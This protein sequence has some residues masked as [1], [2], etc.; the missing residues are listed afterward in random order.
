MSTNI[1]TNKIPRKAYA[2]D[3][4]RRRSKILDLV[5]GATEGLT[6]KEIL[7]KLVS[8]NDDPSLRTV[9]RTL[10]ELSD[11]FRT[12]EFDRAVKKWKWI[13]GAKPK[14]VGLNLNIALT[15]KFISAYLSNYLPASVLESVR[16]I[17][18][19]A[20]QILIAGKDKNLL[21]WETKIRI[22]NKGPQRLPPM[23]SGHIH[24]LIYDALFK[25]EQV[26]IS[27]LSS[28]ASQLKTSEIS[29]LGLVFKDGF[30]YLIVSSTKKKFPYTLALHRIKDVERLY[31][32]IIFPD[33]WKGVDQ[34]I[35][36]GN[37][38][39][40]PGPR[41][42]EESVVLR[43][44]R[45]TFQRFIEMPFSAGQVLVEENADFVTLCTHLSIS[46]ELV[47]WLLQFASDVEIMAPPVL[48]QMMVDRVGEISKMYQS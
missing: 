36:D 20:D 11:E 28:G 41:T 10:V 19:A 44:R 12:F 7:A 35:A 37:F 5:S 32:N 43:I 38:D 47:R 42:E 1:K 26:R 33:N 6:T 24:H 2:T 23:V 18:D 15:F 4:I 3:V 17:S 40:P 31:V 8:E 16:S 22:L 9:Q 21:K 45:K 14:I 48:R 30:T 25:E 27:Y 46:E 29:P 13:S 34:Y 39:F